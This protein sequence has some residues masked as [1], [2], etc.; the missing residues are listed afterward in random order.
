M[1]RPAVALQLYVDGAGAGEGGLV[2]PPHPFGTGAAKQ[3]SQDACT[4]IHGLQH[5]SHTL[6]PVMAVPHAA[7][8]FS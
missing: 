7:V 8:A 4:V 1:H 3:P 5:M 6:Q 2:I